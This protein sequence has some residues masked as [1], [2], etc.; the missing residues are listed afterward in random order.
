[1][2]SEF[3]NFLETKLKIFKAAIPISIYMHCEATLVFFYIYTIR[4]TRY[5][6]TFRYIRES[7]G[8]ILH[9]LQKLREKIYSLRSCSFALSREFRCLEKYPFTL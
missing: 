5:V 4:F 3:L 2:F 6:R 8:I 7:R 9:I 1:M